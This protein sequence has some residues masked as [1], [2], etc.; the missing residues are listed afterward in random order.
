LVAVF[1]APAHALGD[2]VFL[3]DYQTEY[4]ATIDSFRDTLLTYGASSVEFSSVWPEAME[5]YRLIFLWLNESAFTTDQLIDMQNWI[6]SGGLLVLVGENYNFFASTAVLNAV[7]EGLGLESRLVTANYDTGCDH[8]ATVTDPSH[9]LAAGVKELMNAAPG[10]VEAGTDAETVF[11][12]PVG[13]PLVVVEQQ[14]VF[15]ADL[16]LIAD[17][18]AP[19]SEGNHRFFENL[20]DGVCS[21]SDGDGDFSIPCGGTDCDNGDASIFAGAT[22]ITDDGIDQDCDGFDLVTCFEDGDEDGYGSEVVLYGV[23]ACSEE[24]LVD[25]SDD[26]ADDSPEIYPGA[27][28]VP[29]DGIDQDCNGLDSL[30]CYLDSDTDGYGD[31]STALVIDDVESCEEYFMV[32][33]AGDCDPTDVSVYPGAEEIPGDGVDQDCDG[34]DA[35]IVDTGSPAEDTGEPMDGE[36]EEPK[37][38]SCSGVRGIGGVG[39]VWMALLSVLAVGRR[40][41]PRVG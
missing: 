14:V 24:G 1:V 27:S 28:D 32:A 5:D 13:W 34:A 41:S 9:V 22:E 26:C 11:S 7:A 30:T 15:L 35:D 23:G 39:G 8:F 36:A 25:N 20:F 38:C 2:E 10:Y 33:E 40:R 29:D 3:Y 17:N 19:L 37:G 21:D 31:L 18:C 4:Y 12:A 6:D 16:N